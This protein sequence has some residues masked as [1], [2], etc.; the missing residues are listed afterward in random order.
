MIGYMERVAALE[1]A[2][3]RLD[4]ARAERDDALR[5]ALDESVAFVVVQRVTG[6]THEEVRA[7]Q[8]AE[9][10]KAPSR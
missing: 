1:A 7:V 5:A 9:T 6:L 3:A 2:A 8:W 10:T 4:E